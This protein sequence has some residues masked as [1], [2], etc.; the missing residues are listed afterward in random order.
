MNTFYLSIDFIL[1]Y[2]I[3]SLK[4]LIHFKMDGKIK[5][6]KRDKGYGFITGEDEKDYFVH[7]SALPEDQQDVRESD[8]IAVTFTV[9]D[10]DR[11]VQAQEIVFAKSEDVEEA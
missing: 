11:G 3:Y 7:Y 2:V 9:K 10:T 5:W 1:Y 4:H 6:Y 8:N